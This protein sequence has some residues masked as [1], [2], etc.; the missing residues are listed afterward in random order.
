[1]STRSGAKLSERSSRRCAPGMTLVEVLVAAFLGSLVLYVLISTLIPALKA[2]AMGSTRVSLDQRGTL[3]CSRLIRALKATSR[4]G[5]LAETRDGVGLLSTHPLEGILPDSKQKWA[6]HLVIFTGRDGQLRESSVALT[7]PVTRATTL[8][9]E[10][11]VLRPGQLVFVVDHVEE[12]AAT[13]T[14]GPRVDFRLVVAEGKDKLSMARV[15]FL[16]NSSQ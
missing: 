5:L 3:A 6:D 7:P 1:M 2:S 15:V 16:T 12:F 14:D 9:F 4:A 8:P 13:L 11:L 10:D